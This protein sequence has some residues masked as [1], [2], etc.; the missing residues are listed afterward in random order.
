M[1]NNLLKI[2][3]DSP[4][5]VPRILFNN[6]KKLN[7]TEEEL[8]VI[9]LIISLGNKIEF[10]PDI[11]VSE[12]GMDKAKI[13]III[14]SLMDK[15]I[16]SLE[17]IKCGRKMGEYIS[18]SL[19]YDKL[20]N[21]VKDIDEEDKVKIDNSIFTIFENE[22]GRLL[23]PMQIDKIKEWVNTYKNEELIIA[24]LKEAVMNNVSNFNY[25]DTILNEWNKKGYKCKEDTLK[26]KSVY[27]EKKKK[28]SIEIEDID[29]IND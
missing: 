25:I 4:I 6:Y 2:L 12:L 16:L 13:M 21:I 18:L 17:M 9:M 1:D 26:D 23:S 8:V 7:I 10:N 29:W 14:S 24:A 3:Q 11:F 27:R 15:K 20:L 5:F 28:S 19:L 22:L